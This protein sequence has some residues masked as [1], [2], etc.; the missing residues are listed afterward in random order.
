MREDLRF[1][2][3]IREVTIVQDAGRWFACVTVRTSD[4]PLPLTQTFRVGVDVGVKTLATCSDGTAVRQPSCLEA[5]RAEAPARGQVHCQEPER[6]R[7]EPLVSPPDTEVQATG[8]VTRPHKQS[9]GRM[10]SIRPQPR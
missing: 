4:L 2:G 10:P 8:A 1:E 6:S 7:Q 9:Q 5:Q 3:S